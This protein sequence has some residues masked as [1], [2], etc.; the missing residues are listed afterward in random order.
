MFGFG[1]LDVDT[2]KCRSFFGFV[3][4]D[5]GVQ[6][7]SRTSATRSSKVLL[8]PL[9]VVTYSWSVIEIA[10]YCL[11]CDLFEACLTWIL[12]PLFLGMVV[13]SSRNRG[14]SVLARHRCSNV[15]FLDCHDDSIDH[16]DAPQCMHAT[17]LEAWR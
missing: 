1:S 9:R 5:G 13:D 10:L 11:G 16:F 15:T 7:F 4:T 12:E 8:R 2:L 6:L 14:L 17:L 3:G